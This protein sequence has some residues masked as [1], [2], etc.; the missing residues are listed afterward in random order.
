MSVKRVTNILLW[1]TLLVFL[2]LARIQ[3]DILRE[4]VADLSSEL[5]QTKMQ[6]SRYAHGIEYLQLNNPKA[7]DSLINYIQTETE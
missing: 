7:A 1:I 5:F 6:M 2:I 3:V 4:Q